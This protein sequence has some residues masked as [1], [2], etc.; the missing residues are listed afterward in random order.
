MRE[1]SRVVSFWAIC[2]G[3]DWVFLKLEMRGFVPVIGKGPLSQGL[4]REGEAVPARTPGTGALS[5][6]PGGN[7]VLFPQKD[8]YQPNV[9]AGHGHTEGS[10]SNSPSLPLLFPRSVC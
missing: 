7:G 4:S 2:P 3:W 5:P 9:C 10:E 1:L 8:F 6:Q